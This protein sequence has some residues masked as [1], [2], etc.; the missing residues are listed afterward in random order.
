MFKLGSGLRLIFVPL[1]MEDL[2]TF[3]GNDSSLRLQ[4]GDD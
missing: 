2:E 1:K 3:Q 4:L